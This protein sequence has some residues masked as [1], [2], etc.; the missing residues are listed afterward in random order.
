MSAHR[1]FLW[2]TGKEGDVSVSDMEAFLHDPRCRSVSSFRRGTVIVPRNRMD[3]GADARYVLGRAPCLE[4]VRELHTE[5]RHSKTKIKRFMP[6]WHPRTMLR[7]GIFGGKYLND[8]MTEFP[9]EWFQDALSAG[10]LLPGPAR[11]K[12]GEVARQVNLCKIHA[13][14]SLA[15]WQQQGWMQAPDNRGWFQW[16][17]RYAL[18]RRNKEL[19]E[20]QM[21]RWGNF[22]RF[23]SNPKRTAAISQS[24]LHWSY[25]LDYDEAQRASYQLYRDAQ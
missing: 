9:R 13:G 21:R 20:R 7:L 14:Q 25:P 12:E 18:G 6:A 4:D 11:R 5:Y 10:T 15:F 3:Q 19:D 8:C 1:Y 16:F 17:C 24:L 23:Y 22:Q 2:S